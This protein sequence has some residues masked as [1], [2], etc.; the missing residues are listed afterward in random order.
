MTLLQTLKPLS[1]R[2]Q[3][4]NCGS[5]CDDTYYWNQ[6]SQIVM[7]TSIFLQDSRLTTSRRHLMAMIPTTDCALA[8]SVTCTSLTAAP[9]LWNEVTAWNT[10]MPPPIN[11]HL[12][13][14]RNHRSLRHSSSMVATT[15][16]RIRLRIVQSMSVFC[17]SKA[18][19]LMSKA[20]LT[21]P[22]TTL[23][24]SGTRK[25]HLT[26]S[27]LQLIFNHRRRSRILPNGYPSRTRQRN[28]H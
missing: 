12:R 1:R 28:L 16:T 8:V 14:T 17:H 20:I 2:L 24:V 5:L 18:R 4:W 19:E 23:T 27:T 13:T 21:V 9:P 25:A 3:R 7:Q 15:V 22:T 26:E 11:Q 10:N 6:Y